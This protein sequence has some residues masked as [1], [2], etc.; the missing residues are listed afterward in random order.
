MRQV[1]AYVVS[2]LGALLPATNEDGDDLPSARRHRRVKVNTGYF[3]RHDD[4]MPGCQ[5]PLKGR[6]CC[7]SLLCLFKSLAF[8]LCSLITPYSLLPFRFHLNDIVWDA[9]FFSYHSWNLKHPLYT[10][11]LFF[12]T[13]DRLR[14]TRCFRLPHSQANTIA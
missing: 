9:I 2:S 8:F 14:P 1:I 13:L 4:G 3:D 7:V 5:I 6:L 12:Q 11:Y 10:T